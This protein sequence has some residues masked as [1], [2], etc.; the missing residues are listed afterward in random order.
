MLAVLG[1]SSS[2]L[3]ERSLDDAISFAQS[4]GFRAFEVW[5][6]F[7][8]AHPDTTDSTVRRELGRRLAR[9]DRVSVHGPLGNASL[10]S[11]NP[12][13]WKE[14]VRQ[15]VETIRLTQEL[16]ATVLVVHPGELRDPRFREEARQRARDA[17]ATLAEQARRNAIV[18]ALENCGRYLLSIDDTAQDLADLVRA[19]GSEH[20]RVCLDI[21][22]G[23]V[24]KN[25]EELVRLLG[26]EIVHLHVH[27]NHG[28]RD[29][30]L[31][32]GWG[33]IDLSFLRPF[34]RRFDGMAIAE[35]VWSKGKGEHTPEELVK[36]MRN[37]WERVIG[38]RS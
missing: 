32:L 20:L 31:P 28:E 25:N 8:H 24:A 23:A 22:H 18:L 11:T 3:L 37:G 26:N 17:L 19:T 9:F 38:D 5:A 21:G 33:S 36:A 35:I 2:M 34:L 4:E 6:D 29:E 15:H 12:G 16:G 30:H 13:I 7:P 1:L 14:S 27:D 10:A